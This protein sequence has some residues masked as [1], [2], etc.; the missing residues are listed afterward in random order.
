MKTGIW[1]T[2]I[3]FLLAI[4]VVLLFF[5]ITIPAPGPSATG[6]TPT[7]TVPTSTPTANR[8]LHDRVFVR[9]PLSGA[10]VG[11]TFVVTG[12]APGN[13]YFEASFPVEIRD[14]NNN[15]IA[16]THADA[17]SDWMTTEQ[18]PFKVDITV[19]DYSGPATLVLMRDNP[20]GL[21]QYDDSVSIPIFIR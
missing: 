20:S 19:T 18:V 21:P 5:L 2:I 14:A 8:P 15:R 9:T 1:W 6:N 16:Q 11:K 13:W 7:T 12:E 17:L 10:A 3:I 4:I